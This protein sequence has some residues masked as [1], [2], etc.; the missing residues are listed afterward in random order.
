MRLPTAY[1][2]Q[3]GDQNDL[4]TGDLSVNGGSLGV[5]PAFASSNGIPGYTSALIWT[6]SAAIPLSSNGSEYFIFSSPFGQAVPY[7][8]RLVLARCVLP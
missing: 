3:M 5:Q 8:E 1:E 4:P 2:T 7:S 6:A